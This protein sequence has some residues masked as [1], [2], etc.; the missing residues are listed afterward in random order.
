MRILNWF[1]VCMRYMG[2]LRVV[3][4]E[5]YM[6]MKLRMWHPLSWFAVLLAAPLFALVSRQ[7]VQSVWRECLQETTVQI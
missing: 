1:G 7:P 5:K 3:E 2:A 4:G 6:T